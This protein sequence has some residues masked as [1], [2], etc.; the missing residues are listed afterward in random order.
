MGDFQRLQGRLRRLRQ[1]ESWVG[2]P[3]R[4][5]RWIP[6]GSGRR[7]V[8]DVGMFEYINQWNWWCSKGYAL[9]Y[10]G[11]KMITMH[12]LVL[13]VRKGME[14]DHKD[15]DRL[16]NRRKNLR[17]C[18]KIQNQGNRWKPRHAKSSKF[19]GVWFSKCC[20]L[21]V[22]EGTEN[23]RKVSFGY[24]QSEIDAAKAYNKWAKVHFGEFAYLNPV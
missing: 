18:T 8:V 22:A 4:G 3:K 20:K 16:N 17:P 12:S 6:L 24:F 5:T 10:V 9:R 11:R 23:G 21:F 1:M 14:I 13:K 15:R 7:A 2:V 19:K